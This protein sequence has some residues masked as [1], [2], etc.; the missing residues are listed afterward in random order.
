MFTTFSMD[1]TGANCDQVLTATR[2]V[3]DPCHQQE[4]LFYRKISQYGSWTN[5]TLSAVQFGLSSKDV[6]S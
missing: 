2:Y 6:L 1:A 4:D 3:V 5:G